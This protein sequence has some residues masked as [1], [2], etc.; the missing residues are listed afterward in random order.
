M[1][2]GIV[3]ASLSENINYLTLRIL[4]IFGPMGDTYDSLV[5]GLSALEF[6]LGNK[7]VGGKIF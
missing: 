6:A 5:A 4:G 2:L 7:D 3:L 1:N